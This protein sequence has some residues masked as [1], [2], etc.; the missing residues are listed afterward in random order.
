MKTMTRNSTLSSFN[1]WKS[2]V[3]GILEME[4]MTFRISNQELELLFTY[5]FFIN[6]NVIYCVKAWVCACV[7]VY[8]HFCM[9]MH[10]HVLIIM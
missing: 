6:F 8:L 1:H 7:C 4:R 9:Y 10:M 3:K 5:D 2:N